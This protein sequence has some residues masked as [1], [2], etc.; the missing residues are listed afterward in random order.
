ML[1]HYQT[2]KNFQNIA[3]ICYTVVRYVLYQAGKKEFLYLGGDSGQCREDE[4]QSSNTHRSNFTARSGSAIATRK[5]QISVKKYD[6]TPSLKDTE[7]KSRSSIAGSS[8]KH[9]TP[10]NFLGKS[11]LNA[12]SFDG[13]SMQQSNSK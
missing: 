7:E 5:S 3:N 1:K 9:K 10:R 12:K 13:S 4:V 2:N 8:Q 6:P 11:P